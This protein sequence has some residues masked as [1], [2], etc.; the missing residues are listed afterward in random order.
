MFFERNIYQFQPIKNNDMQSWSTMSRHSFKTE[1]NFCWVFLYCYLILPT[2]VY[3]NWTDSQKLVSWNWNKPSY[4][5]WGYE[6]LAGRHFVDF[7]V[8]WQN[9]VLAAY[10]KKWAFIKRSR[11]TPRKIAKWLINDEFCC[12]LKKW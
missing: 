5:L 8:D 6:R 3:Q 10:Q 9:L 7:W 4:E 2:K 11:K 1:D 12:V